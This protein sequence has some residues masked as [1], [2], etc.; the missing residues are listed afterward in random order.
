MPLDNVNALREEKTVTPTQRI[1]V[2]HDSNVSEDRHIRHIVEKIIITEASASALL[3]FTDRVHRIPEVYIKGITLICNKEVSSAGHAFN[4]E[5]DEQGTQLLK[6]A[7]FIDEKI[8]YRLTQVTVKIDFKDVK[9]SKVLHF[10][11]N[12][13]AFGE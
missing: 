7:F 3:V 9:T 12:F 13:E 8:D 1:F 10:E 4:Y 6:G 2:P 11:G 5:P